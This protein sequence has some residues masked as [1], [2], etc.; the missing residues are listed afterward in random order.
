MSNYNNLY[1]SYPIS[2]PPLSTTD[3]IKP[4]EGYVQNNIGQD[5]I[6]GLEILK[7]GNIDFYQNKFK[8]INIDTRR[9]EFL[10]G[11]Q[12]TPFATVLSCCDSRV[13]T[14]IVFNRGVGDI[15]T[16]RSAGE[17]LDQALIGSIQYSIEVLGV[18][19]V[20]I[21]GHTDCGAVNASVKYWRDQPYEKHIQYILNEIGPAAKKA[22][23]DDPENPYTLA[24]VYQINNVENQLRGIFERQNIRTANIMFVKCIYDMN[25]GQ[26]H[27]LS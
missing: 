7:K 2:I 23:M 18:K 21:M 26:V 9:I 3:S 27:W 5:P 1:Y 25:T 16:A 6:M 4:C 22:L 13:P 8:S 14:E 15:F 19:L 17:V 20:V 10:R 11:K 12:Q 24:T